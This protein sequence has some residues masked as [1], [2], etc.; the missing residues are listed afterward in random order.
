S[1]DEEITEFYFDIPFR[2]LVPQ[3]VENLL[4]AGKPFHEMRSMPICMMTGEAAGTAAA[5]AAST[6][7]VVREVDMTKLQEWLRKA[8]VIL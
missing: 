4:V 6:N 7:V 8:N 5:L 2:M 1:V 3:K